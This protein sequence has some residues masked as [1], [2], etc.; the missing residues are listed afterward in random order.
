M[1]ALRIQLADNPKKV[2]HKGIA[3][4][5]AVLL[6]GSL[7]VVAEEPQ[8]TTEYLYQK[9]L[10][11]ILL[12]EPAF[13]ETVTR[14]EFLTV[15][16]KAFK[17]IPVPTDEY[18][19]ADV[20]SGNSVADYVYSAVQLGYVSRDDNFYPDNEITYEEAVKLVVCFLG[21]HDY[22]EYNGGYPAGYLRTAQRIKLLD[23][24][25]QNGEFDVAAA[26]HLVFNALH[27]NGLE[28][29]AIGSVNEYSDD[30]PSVLKRLYD[31]D[32]IEGI[33][34]GTAYNSLIGDAASGDPVVYID[35]QGY[36]YEDS[37]PEM[38][39]RYYRA[40]VDQNE[41]VIYMYP[42]ENS[43]LTLE[44]RDNLIIE[45]SDLVYIDPDTRVDKTYRLDPAFY[46]IYN[47][48]KAEVTDVEFDGLLGQV[49]L[50]DSGGDQRYETVY[51]TEYDYITVS[52]YTRTL[53]RISDDKGYELDL[54]GDVQTVLYGADGVPASLSSLQSGDVL[55]V[56]KSLDGK[57][58]SLYV[59]SGNLNGEVSFVNTTERTLRY[60]DATYYMS[61]Y[62]LREYNLT[63]GGQVSLVIDGDIVVALN[64]QAD[65]YQYGYLMNYAT[66]TGLGKEI[67]V[68]MLN[69]SSQ[70]EVCTLDRSVTINGNRYRNFDSQSFAD[71]FL[72]D[73]EFQPQLIRYRQNAQGQITGIDTAVVN[74]VA[75]LQIPD[76]E[77]D[78]LTQYTFQESTFL[79]KS[80]YQNCAPYFN[81][82]SALVFVIPSDPT[83]LDKYAVRSA[84]YFYNNRRVSMQV[85]DL[86]ENLSAGAVV[87]TED[88]STKNLGSVDTY[89]ITDVARALDQEGNPGYQLELWCN[90]RYYYYFAPDELTVIKNAAIYSAADP[91]VLCR[92]DLVRLEVDSSD[93]IVTMIVDFDANPAVFAPNGGNAAP[94]NGNN[95][96]PMYQSGR[97][98]SLSNSYITLASASAGGDYSFDLSTLRQF[99]A[100]TTNVV[101]FDMERGMTIDASLN[102][103]KTWI[104][105]GI[106]AQ[107]V[108]LRQNDYRPMSLIIYEGMEE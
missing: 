6:V 2:F 28:I 13:E 89:L 105:N 51:L 45:G 42:E 24:V 108:I 25:S 101:I 69:Q 72:A 68:R 32:V 86:D 48:K 93:Q 20:T 66:T 1:R 107:F 23:N 47:G 83:Q 14:A 55:R 99:S 58:L 41:A 81:L 15:V 74:D 95:E 10:V 31:I 96:S 59:V 22:A 49:M 46:F 75:H 9:Q 44:I 27:A 3:V 21:Y 92:G 104:S 34:T 79:Y 103:I 54:S 43:T 19:F 85:Y 64:Q 71:L 82:A 26:Y 12:E 63:V 77:A 97:V 38:L 56:V 91:S 65:T 4:F 94:F 36:N 18:F 78:K 88:F 70:L 67:M 57:L 37:A 52:R 84:S 30:G 16:S 73:G 5:L 76:N 60:E 80:S 35:G 40:Y 87:F 90:S 106:E 33:V 8:E 62:F 102:D 17:V 100:N 7:A 29:Q 98:Y 50:L 39:G 61:D 11:D 53:E